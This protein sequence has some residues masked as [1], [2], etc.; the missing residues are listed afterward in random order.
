MFSELDIEI[1]REEII[2]SI[3]QLKNGKKVEAQ[4]SY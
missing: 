3:G 1:T 4:I 2:I